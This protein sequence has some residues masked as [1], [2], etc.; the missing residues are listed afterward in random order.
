MSQP[1][2]GVAGRPAGEP[3]EFELIDRFFD[4]GPARR[5]VLGIGD[6][7]ALISPA[8]GCDLAVSTDML[9]VGTHFF[10]DADPASLGHNCLAVTLSDL[11]AKGARPSAFT[12]ALSLPAVDEAWLA[13][14]S[15]GLFALADRYDCELIGGDTT[16]GPLNLCI[17]VFGDVPRGAALRRDHAEPGDDL[18]LS[19]CTGA[20]AHAVRRRLRGEPLPPDDPAQLR[21]DRPEPRVALGLFLR[22]LARAAIDVSDGVLGDLGHICRRSRVGAEIDWPRVPLPPSLRVLDASEAMALVLAGG[23]DYEL[24]FTAAPENRAAIEGCTLEHGLTRIGRIVPGDE[25]RVLDARGA[26]IAIDV[27][28]FEHFGS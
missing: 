17:T 6:D 15:R 19:G 27:T 12:L 8:P 5:A 18:W 26:R 25:I 7:C 4:R 23:D 13:A 1:S 21:L 2:R 3:R 10:D 9:V 20:A 11:A 16:R 22:H 14:F 24:L 28:G